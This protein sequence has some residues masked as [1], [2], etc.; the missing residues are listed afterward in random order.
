MRVIPKT[1]KVKVQFFKN[2]SVADI[3]IALIAIVLIVVICLSN[4]GIARFFIAAIVLC[5]T[6]GLFIPY[7]GQRFYFF[8]RTFIR[9]LF[10]GKK[11]VVQDVESASNVKSFFAFKN[12]H[13]GYIEFE[14]YYG[15]VLEIGSREFRLL[16]SFR[17]DQIINN[18][19]GSAFI[20]TGPQSRTSIDIIASQR[21]ASLFEEKK[22]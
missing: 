6:I 17:Q 19:R 4:I 14:N 1:A 12:V 2:I 16:T 11:F 15:G 22:A 20:I 7:D 9:Y 18:A 10:S 5:L 21:V 13:G 3:L 8:F